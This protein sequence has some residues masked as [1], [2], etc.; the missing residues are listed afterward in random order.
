[1]SNGGLATTSLTT[2]ANIGVVKQFTPNVVKP[3]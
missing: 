3:G 1:L 2:Q